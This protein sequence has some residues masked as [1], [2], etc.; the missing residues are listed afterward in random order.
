MKI[1]QFYSATVLIEE[2]TK[3]LC[4]PW[5]TGSGLGGSWA[6]YPPYDFKPEVFDGVDYIYISH[7]HH[8]HLS[9]PTLERLD[10]SIPVLI[11]EFPGK[12][13]KR[14]IESAGFEA[15]ELQHNTQMDL[16]NGMSIDILAADDCNPEICGKAMGCTEWR[17]ELGTLQIDTMA[18]IKND[19][20]TIVNI[21]DCPYP[22]AKTVSEKIKFQYGDI[23]LLL[24]GYIKAASHP[25]CFDY[26]SEK[27]MQMAWVKQERKLEENAEY[28]RIFKPRYFMPFA[29]SYILAGKNHV[30]EEYRGEPSL[31]YALKWYSAK[32]ADSP[33]KCI[34]LSSDTTFDIE[35][36]VQSKPFEKIDA[37]EKEKY[38]NDVLVKAR[39]DWDDDPIPSWESLVSLLPE[40]YARFEKARGRYMWKSDTNILI[41]VNDKFIKVSCNGSG[42]DI[43]GIDEAED[44]RPMLAMDMDIRLL[45]RILRGPKYCTWGIADGG[46][47]VTYRREPDNYE[48]GLY[49]CLAHF[50]SGDVT[51][52]ASSKSQL[53]QV[54]L[55]S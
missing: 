25:A 7:I 6:Q 8:D 45:Y 15:I 19:R 37:A 50:Y 33:Y 35:S 1:T 54:N 17:K 34:G 51:P 44:I 14:I 10:K 28:V 55:T 42:Y 21:N 5:L 53:L 32:F 49:Y 9:V 20:H 18:V 52:V 4:D 29:G 41:R 26:P 48:R 39:Y 43:I 47:H 31:E 3:I 11:H 40:A 2:K 12:G 13:M 23:D 30:L 27:K 36:G 38:I 22:I 16:G 46:Y 24:M